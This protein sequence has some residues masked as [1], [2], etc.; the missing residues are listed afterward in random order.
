MNCTSMCSNFRI[1]N[2]RPCCIKW[3]MITLLNINRNYYGNIIF[4]QFKLEYFMV[5]YDHSG[6]CT[7]CCWILSCSRPTEFK[8]N[9]KKIVLVNGE[10]ETCSLIGFVYRV[11]W[12]LKALW[13]FLSETI[14]FLRKLHK[15]TVSGCPRNFYHRVTCTHRSL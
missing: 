13:I 4:Q 1:K 9:L 5:V 14:N 3:S 7:K 10:N 11:V 15:L 6:K 8:A 12:V 2:H